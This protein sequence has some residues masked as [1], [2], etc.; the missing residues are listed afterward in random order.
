MNTSSVVDDKWHNDPL[1]QDL[2]SDGFGGFNSLLRLGRLATTP[3]SNAKLGDGEIDAIGL[4]HQPRQP[5]YLQVLDMDDLLLRY[6]TLSHDVQRVWL[7]VRDGD[8]LPMEPV[9]V[10][11]LFTYW[12]IHVPTSSDDTAP[13]LRRIKY[14]FV[15]EDGDKRASASDTYTYTFTN[16]AV[17]DIPEWAKHAV[18]YQ[19]FPERFRNGDKENDPEQTRPWTSE[20]FTPSP[21]EESSGETFYDEYAF[22]RFYGGDIAG[23]EEQLPYLKA[24]GVN[25]LYLNPVFA[26]PTNHKYDVGNYLH[27]DPHFGTPDRYEELL[28]E[29]DLMAPG[30]WQWTKS[31]RRFLDFIAK[32]HEMGFKVIVDGVFNHVGA[33]HPAYVDIVCNGKISP[34]ADWFD[35]T[36]WEP[37]VIAGWADVAEMPVFKKS[38]NGFAAAAV[39]QHLFDITRRWMDPDGDGDPSDG[40]DGWRLDVPIEVPRPFWAEWRRHVKSINP[41]AYL[42]GE[43]WYRADQWLDGHHFDAVMNYEFAKVAVKWIID[44]K[45]K[46]SASEAATRLEELRLVYPIAATYALQTLLDSHDTDRLASMAQNPDR[47]YDRKNRVQDNGPDYDNGKPSAAAYARARLLVLLQM[48]YVGAPMIYYGDEVGMWG[49]DDPTNRKPM[50]WKDLEPY[51]NPTENAVMQDHLEFYKRVIALR[52]EHPALATGAFDTLLTDDEADVWAF[53][54][55]GEGERVLVVLNASDTPREVGIPLTDDLPQS[56]QG[57][58]GSDETLAADDGQLTV[59][60]PAVGGVVLQAAGQ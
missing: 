7:A 37:L 1:N 3:S 5:L 34:F 14:T 11:P 60:V 30:T 55:S 48:T 10:G 23:I 44:H 58:F 8:E 36:S 15:L 45:L 17:F 16:R 24:L 33:E 51:E 39:R 56:W 31:D 53:L 27:I 12:Q 52:R 47:E 49:A 57:V 2:A 19:I 29:E 26:A 59:S 28:S 18:W 38:Y 46:I 32:A 25:A 42:T 9:S 35:V 54:R 41:D 40:I 4:E 6:R 13:G 20:W 43:I 22:N 21:W 50:L